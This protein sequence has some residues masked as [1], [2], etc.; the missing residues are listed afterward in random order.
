MDFVASVKKDMVSGEEH[1][2][3]YNAMKNCKIIV[4]L[5]FRTILT[6]MVCALEYPRTTVSCIIEEFVLPVGQ[7]TI[8]QVEVNVKGQ[9][10]IA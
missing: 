5:V 10:E 8:D 1:A 7:D 6:S 4:T 9:S 3:N 2:K